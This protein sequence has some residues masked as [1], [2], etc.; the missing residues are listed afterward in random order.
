MR[1]TRVAKPVRR[2]VTLGGGEVVVTLHADGRITFREL[3]HRREYPL[4][5][6]QLFVRAVELDELRRQRALEQIEMPGV[7]ERAAE[8]GAALRG[9]K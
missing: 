1:I 4:Q 3:R 5:L 7:L 8:R 9:E 6:G 2:V